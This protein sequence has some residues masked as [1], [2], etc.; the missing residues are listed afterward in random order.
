MPRLQVD[1][2]T[3]VLEEV[4]SRLTKKLFQEYSRTVSRILGALSCLEDFL[5]NLL[6]QG[7]SGTAPETS[8][9]TLRTNQG[10]NRDDSQSDPHPKAGV[11]QSQTTN[12]GPD[13]TYNNTW[14]MLQIF[15]PTS[16]LLE[17][18]YSK[19]C[20]SRFRFLFDLLD[21]RFS[22]SLAFVNLWWTA[23]RWTS[24]DKQVLWD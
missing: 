1:Y 22:W 15:K 7:H 24:I 11:S 17:L 12:S 9:N 20:L 6:I 4:E 23:T 8:R 10:T 19:A 5:P 2:I 21:L 14:N 3:Q 18:F 13:D 16:F